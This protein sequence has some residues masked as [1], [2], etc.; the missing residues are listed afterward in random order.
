MKIYS[1]MKFTIGIPYYKYNFFQEC[2]DSI[3]AQTFDDFELIIV[4]DKSP[5]DISDEIKNLS[6]YRINYHVNHV[7]CGSEHVVDNWN[8]CLK[9]A[10]GE[11][12]I[13]M[14]DD[15][16]MCV[17]YL[18]EFDRLIHE[19]PD[20][21][22]LHC[23]S[24]LINEESSVVSITETRPEFES[25]YDSIIQRIKGSRLFFISDYV[26]KTEVLKKNGGFFKLPLA[27]ASD[28]ITSYIAAASNGI[29]H[30]NKP[31]FK[32]RL[33][34]HTISTTGNVLLKMDAIMQEEQWLKDFLSI[35]VLKTDERLIRDS[36]IKYRRKYIQKKKMRTI[37]SSNYKYLIS[38]F[39]KWFR[40]RKKYEL[41]I[42]ELLYTLVLAVKERKVS[43]YE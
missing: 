40:Y 29:A 42:A 10:R 36:I 41:S 24:Y 4:N 19:Y 22:V 3:L 30:T 21:D 33:S 37:Y 14:G 8:K 1:N 31:L 43:R 17:N 13:L 7:N 16:V 26:Y 35:E 27:W 20:V 39:I 15:D 38:L 12:F 28:D 9:H 5:F 32:Y 11:Y 18:E 2:L 6:D 23:R 25:V 34:N